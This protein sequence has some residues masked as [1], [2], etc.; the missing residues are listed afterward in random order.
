[1][2]QPFINYDLPDSHKVSIL[3]V[4]ISIVL[5]SERAFHC[6]FDKVNLRD[7]GELLVPALRLGVGRVLDLDPVGRTFVLNVG[8]VFPFRHNAFQVQRTGSLVES[9]APWPSSWSGI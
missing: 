3:S 7:F 6:Y 1:M 4:D 2:L 8:A 9:W 5:L